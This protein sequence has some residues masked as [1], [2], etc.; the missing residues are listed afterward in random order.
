M[1]GFAPAG[2]ATGRANQSAEVRHVRLERLAPLRR[3]PQPG[4]R[5]AADRALADADVAGL[6]ERPRVLAQLRIADAYRVADGRELA[7]VDAREQRAH[8]QARER[9]DDRVRRHLVR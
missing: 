8:R 2:S 6:L 5:P 4:P 1:R 9:V 7:L 3:E